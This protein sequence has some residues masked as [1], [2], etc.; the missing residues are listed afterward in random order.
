MRKAIQLLAVAIVA[1]LA[2]FSARADDSGKCGMNV[3]WKMYPTAGNEGYY[4][5]E[6]SGRGAM[7][8]YNSDDNRT[9]MEWRQLNVSKIII[10]E[11]ITYIGNSAFSFSQSLTSVSFPSTLTVIGGSAFNGCSSLRTVTLPKSLKTIGD[12]AFYGCSSL[13]SVTFPNSLTSIGE[14]AF[15]DCSSLRSVMLPKSL[16]SMGMDAFSWSGLTSV[17]LPN[18]LTLIPGYAFRGCK[19]L[20]SITLPSSVAIIEDNAFS[21]CDNLRVINV[22]RKVPPQ[23]TWRAFCWYTAAEYRRCRLNVPAGSEVSYRSHPAWRWFY[24][25]NKQTTTKRN[26]TTRYRR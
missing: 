11:G 6:I 17:T 10:K 19:S 7:Y 2:S 25:T 12:C 18:S 26:R 5:L 22:L 3:E 20:T 15:M 24:K 9:P 8:N 14:C 4:T 21:G 16:K 23:C 1:L 13:T